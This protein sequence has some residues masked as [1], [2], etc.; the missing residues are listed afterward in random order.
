MLPNIGP[1]SIASLTAFDGSTLLS[2]CICVHLRFQLLASCGPH[3][4]SW[5]AQTWRSSA[6]RIAARNWNRRCTLM[7]ADEIV[8]NWGAVPGVRAWR[9]PS[10]PHESRK[11]LIHGSNNWTMRDGLSSEIDFLA[12]P[13]MSYPA[14]LRLTHRPRTTVMPT[15]V[16][17][18]PSGICIANLRNPAN[19]EDSCQAANFVSPCPSYCQQPSRGLVHRCPSV[20]QATGRAKRVSTIS[21]PGIKR[22]HRLGLMVPTQ[23]IGDDCEFGIIPSRWPAAVSGARVRDLIPTARKTDSRGIPNCA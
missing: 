2:A 11:T 14:A 3:P 15:F 4:G 7:H 9:G 23:S 21:Q 1:K 19:H 5:S 16:G 13:T 18:T 22:P 6:V 10:D 20:D 17:M 8:R 12:I